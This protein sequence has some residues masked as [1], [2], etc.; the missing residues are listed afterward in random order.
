MK[1]AFIGG[2]VMAEAIIKGV[3]SA[4]LAKPENISVGEVQKSRRELLLNNYSVVT[5]ASNE[6]AI[7]NADFVILSIKPQ[8][9]DDVASTLKSNLNSNQTVLSI[10]AGL[11]LSSIT[12]ALDHKD[13]IRVMPNTPTQIG[14]GISIWICSPSVTTDKQDIT[15]NLLQTLG[16]NIQVEN[17]GYINMA[18][19]LSGSGPAYVFLFVESLIDA[20]VFM[21]LPRSMAQSLVLQTVIGSTRLIQESGKHTTVLKDMVTSPGGTTAEALLALEEGGF[22]S[23]I[24]N[25]VFAA[26]EKSQE[27]G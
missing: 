16:E 13:V 11:T 22:K 17:E 26:Y 12:S 14:E 19:A 4:S 27:L 8:T 25:A 7:M 20:G 9:F 21:G 3:L 10:I 18:T 24:I 23:T 5:T 1:L 2:G 15:R 6:E